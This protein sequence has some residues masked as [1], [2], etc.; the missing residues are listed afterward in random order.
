MIGDVSA[1][2]AAAQA[3]AMQAAPHGRPSAAHGRN[4]ARR[5]DA[6]DASRNGARADG[7]QRH[8]GFFG[9][10]AWNGHG[11]PTA[12]AVRAAVSANGLRPTRGAQ[13]QHRPHRWR[14]RRRTGA[15]RCRC[16]FRVLEI[17][18][19]RF[20]F[21]CSGAAPSA[22]ADVSG[23]SSSAPSQP[24]AT[25]AATAIATATAS[26]TPSAKP[27]TSTATSVKKPIV[28]PTGVPT[29]RPTAVPTA[30]PTAKPVTSAHK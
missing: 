16:W 27:A 29:V 13:E 14:R 24:T 25:A 11:R 4:D 3:S 7:H 17:T 20:R 30:K 10:S 21:R 8:D 6:R 2:T 23:S 5:A 26:T 9:A 18:Q 15:R 12:A 1:L 28:Q 22:Q 19:V